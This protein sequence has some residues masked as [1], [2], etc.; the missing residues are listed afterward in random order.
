MNRTDKIDLTK[1]VVRAGGWQIVKR[2]SRSVPFA[3][4]VIAV[5]LAGN[6]IRRKG[7]LKGALDVGLDVLPVI[8]TAKNIVEIF[9]GDLISDKEPASK[10]GARNKGNSNDE[11]Q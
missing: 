6:S 5:G 9:T 2:L 4:T 11:K 8:G 10:N 3:G 7:L 1:R